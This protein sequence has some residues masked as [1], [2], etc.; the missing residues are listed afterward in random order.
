MIS[1]KIVLYGGHGKDGK[2]HCETNELKN[3]GT[4]KTKSFEDVS[5]LTMT[6]PL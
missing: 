4:C 3:G 5:S 2:L 1:L 6:E